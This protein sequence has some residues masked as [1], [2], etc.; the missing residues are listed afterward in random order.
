MKIFQKFPQF[1]FFTSIRL[2]TD[3]G[4]QFQGAKQW[5]H[6]GQGRGRLRKLVQLRSHS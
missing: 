2:K 3:L 4:V 6:L 5:R 1:K